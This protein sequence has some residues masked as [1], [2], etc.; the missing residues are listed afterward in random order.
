MNPGINIPQFSLILIREF[1][2]ENWQLWRTFRKK[3]LK[4]EGPSGPSHQ[5]E[6]CIEDD[7]LR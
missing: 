2:L 6:A 4:N 3:I 1:L 5:R 7:L